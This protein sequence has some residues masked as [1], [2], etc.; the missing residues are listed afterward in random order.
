MDVS[1]VV[2]CV[3]ACIGGLGT[4][5]SAVGVVLPAGSSVGQFCRTAGADLK[6]L[7][8]FESDVESV[9]KLAEKK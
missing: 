3:F 5:F 2:E 4:I 6:K 9:S 7:L 1:A 8:G